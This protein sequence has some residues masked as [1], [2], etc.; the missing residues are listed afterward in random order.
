MPCKWVAGPESEQAFPSSLEAM[1]ADPPP[2]DDLRA[3]FQRLL[4][5]ALTRGRAT[6]KCSGLGPETVAAID[7]V[8]YDH[9]DAEAEGIAAAYD[10][11][12]RE[13]G[14]ELA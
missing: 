5:L 3:T 8:A 12:D 1:S 13:H 10:T 11:F 4:N 14:E 2:P 9:P 6:P 7:G